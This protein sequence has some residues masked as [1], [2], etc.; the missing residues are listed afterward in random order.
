MILK[1]CADDRGEVLLNFKLS[2]EDDDGNFQ[3]T[4]EQFLKTYAKQ[5]V[6][7]KGDINKNVAQEIRSF[8]SD[9][10]GGK[11]VCSPDDIPFTQQYIWKAFVKFSDKIIWDG[12]LKDEG[13]MDWNACW[14]KRKLW[15]LRCVFRESARYVVRI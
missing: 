2:H 7:K 8:V 3:D 4:L 1:H 9:L 15:T 14:S 13:N 11:K 12:E 6:T 5:C 10:K